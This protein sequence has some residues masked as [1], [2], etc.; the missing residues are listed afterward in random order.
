MILRQRNGFT[1]VELLVVIAIIGVLVA[2]L[3]PA[4]QA[5]RES[6]RR[7]QCNNNLKQ[8]GLAFHNHENTHE[9]LPTGGWG[10][11]WT[12]DPDRGF[13]PDQPGGWTYNILPYIELQ[14][15]HNL[16]QDG[17][18]DVITDGQRE[19]AAQR[20]QIPVPAFICPS[21]RA[22]DLYPFGISPTSGN[23]M[24]YIC[25]NSTNDVERISRCDYA[26]SVGDIKNY[27]FKQPNDPDWEKA[28]A[29]K[30]DETA[31][32][33]CRGVVYQRS[34]VEFSQ[35][36]DGTSH[37]YMVGEKYLNPDAYDTGDDWTD[38]ET[39]YSGNNDDTLRTA[40]AEPLP[41]QPGL[42]IQRRFGSSHPGLWHMVW[43]DG[44][45]RGLSFDIALD[46]H[47]ALSTR[48]DG[49]VVDSTQL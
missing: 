14:N 26:A 33:K 5:A 48:D 4:V 24:S 16:G 43:C 1:L 45:V 2:L 11:W 25:F 29:F 8:I 39:I 19:G 23:Q 46:I 31:K 3:L 37:T 9:F 42:P 44:S 41:D 13:G 17:Q 35:I 28:I 7:M 30:W 6:A 34:Q 32:D 40:F 36:S 18:P 47:R 12:S 21:R 27:Q 10:W 15:L 20:D 38:I 22:V 49:N